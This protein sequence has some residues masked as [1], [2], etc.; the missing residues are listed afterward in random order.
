MTRAL[1]DSLLR[2]GGVIVTVSSIGARVIG[3]PLDYGVAK[4]AL[5]NLTK[6]LSEEYAPRGVRAVT[7]SPGPTR[8][9][10]WT[11]PDSAAGGLARS[12]GIGLDQLV[13]GVPA[14]MGISTGRLAEPE[15]TAATIAFLASPWAGSITGTDVL[16]DGG[17]VKTV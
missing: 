15:E 14:Q 8:T 7:V 5:T 3:P 10:M 16:V 12:L 1:V 2:R 9:G 13:A 4:A 17:A 6:A 11:D